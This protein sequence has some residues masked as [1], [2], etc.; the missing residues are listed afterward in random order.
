MSTALAIASVSAVLKDLLNNGLVDHNLAS[1]VGNVVVSALSPDRIDQTGNQQ[2]QL[3]LFLYQVTPNAAWRNVGLP[4]RDARGDR[5]GNPPLA[6]DL[7][8]LLTAYGALEFHAEVLLGYGMQLLHETPILT[9]TAIRMALAPPS[10]VSPGGSLPQGLQALFTSELAEQVEQ[11]KITPETLNTEEISRMWTAFQA[12]YRPT[13]AYHVSVVLIESKAST[14]SPLP[15]RARRIYVVPFK[16]PFIAQVN[17]QETP[18]GPILSRQ[19]II[20]SHRLVLA[21]HTLRAEGIQ[22]LVGGVDSPVA[23]ADVTD[24]QVI[25]PIPATLRAGLQGVQVIHPR[26]MGEPPA[27][28]R[29]V[30]SNLAAFVLHPRID[31]V[32]ASN[33]QG[34]GTQPRSAD[35][36]VGVTPA[37]GDNQRVVL[38]LNQF[39]PAG[40]PPGSPPQ[41]ARSESYS[42][43]APSRLP[44]SPPS[45]GPGATN[46]VVIPITGVKGGAY[47]VRVQV[48]GADSPLIVDAS[49][50]FVS[51]L[52][53]IP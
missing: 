26:F 28:H 49:G 33:V 39:N 5:T 4:G 25:V 51:P 13:A 30:E 46:T 47:L 29:G 50:Q 6:L 38:L 8:Y 45:L 42:F 10:P 27:P 18:G 32:T 43:V 15:V 17:S 24:Q 9:R 40:S 31:S 14:K 12:H 48:D 53:L 41:D 11:I 22:V 1:T 36:A 7:H 23:D 34:T 44:L 2:S 19:P 52:V 20:A 35:V 3:N 37:V 21:G 16:Q